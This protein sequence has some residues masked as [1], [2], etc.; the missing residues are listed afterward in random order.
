M[1][2]IGI[3]T[4]LMHLILAIHVSRK[5][6]F[7]FN[8]YKCGFCNIST[9]NNIKCSCLIRMARMKSCLASLGSTG[10]KL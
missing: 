8:I 3:L 6:S 4:L 5:C 7:V 10:F 1:D 2:K 9:S